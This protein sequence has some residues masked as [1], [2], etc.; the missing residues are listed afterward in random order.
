VAASRSA[1]G[2][3]E[4]VLVST[5][6]PR[7]AR[8]PGVLDATAEPVEAEADESPADEEPADESAEFD[9]DEPASVL[10]ASAVGIATTAD[11][12]PNATASAPT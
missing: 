9:V 11:P 3:D 10:S 12:T 2:A 5:R 1:A 6:L 8:R 7:A 4:V